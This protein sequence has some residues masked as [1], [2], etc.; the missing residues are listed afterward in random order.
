MANKL[1]ELSYSNY[2][3]MNDIIREE[4]SY[5]EKRASKFKLIKEESEFEIK[6][7]LGHEGKLDANYYGKLMYMLGLKAK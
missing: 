1:I 5:S 6:Y 7:W 4:Y 2:K 3:I